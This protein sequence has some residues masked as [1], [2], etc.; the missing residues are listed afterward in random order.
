MSLE[1]LQTIKPPLRHPANTT[2]RGD[3]QHALEFDSNLPGECHR[4]AEPRPEL[5]RRTRSCTWSAWRNVKSMRDPPERNTRFANPY[6]QWFSA[7]SH[8][9]WTWVSVASR[10]SRGSSGSW[11]GG[12][13]IAAG[14]YGRTLVAER[15]SSD[16]RHR[17][18][19]RDVRTNTK[20]ANTAQALDPAKPI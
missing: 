18:T 9:K 5:I 7:E 16:G 12:P 10:R 15:G 6:A 3:S 17:L 20:P 13:P 8:R 19:A 14:R 1:N 11:G 2:N 4:L